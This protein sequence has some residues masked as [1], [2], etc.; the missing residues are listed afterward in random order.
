MIRYDTYV[1]QYYKKDFDHCKQYF[2]SLNFDYKLAI[3]FSSRSMK[4]AAVIFYSFICYSKDLVN[5]SHQKHQNW[6]HKSFNEFTYEWKELF[7]KGPN[8]HTHPVLRATYYLFKKYEIPFD[9]TFDFLATAR[10]GTN[11][12]HYRSYAELQQYMWG[13][14]AVIGHILT[15]VAGYHNEKAFDYVRSLS[16]ALQLTN[17]L[18]YIDKDYQEDYI[19]LPQNDMFLFAV[20]EEMIAEQKMTTQ[21]HNFVRHYT[22]RTESLFN[23]GIKGI[24]YLKSGKF[25]LFLLSKIQQRNIQIL[26]KRNYDIFAQPIKISRIRIIIILL[27]T[28]IKYPFLIVRN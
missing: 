20:T 14:S 13:K 8:E 26:K 1:Q 4:E 2:S 28:L 21:L 5:Q 22:E 12:N 16:E 10:Q 19:Y 15:F 24:S 7:K 27:L 25:S 11:Q 3:I 23:D 9:Y 17:I 18:R 6:E